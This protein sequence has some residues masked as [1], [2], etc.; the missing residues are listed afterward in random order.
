MDGHHWWEHPRMAMKEFYGYYYHL[1]PERIN[2]IRSVPYP[3]CWL[4]YCTIP[5][6]WYSITPCCKGRS[7]YLCGMSPFYSWYWCEHW[8]QGESVHWKLI[9]IAVWIYSIF[10]VDWTIVRRMVI[11]HYTLL[12]GVV[13]LLLWNISFLFLVLMWTLETRWV[14]PLKVNSHCKFG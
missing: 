11:L 10:Q 2:L 14:S 3:L 4:N 13:I 7:Y 8:K 5:V 6:W 12:Q 9:D 1:V